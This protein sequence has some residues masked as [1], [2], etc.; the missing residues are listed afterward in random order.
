MDKLY[1][2]EAWLREE[3]LVKGRM[4]EDL[5]KELSVDNSTILYWLHKYNIPVRPYGAHLRGK[6]LSNDHREKLCKA[7]EGRKPMLGKHHSDA[8]KKKFSEI[9]KR[10]NL[11]EETRKKLSEASKGNKRGAG[12]I[13][14]DEHKRKIGQSLKGNKHL[15][16]H[17]HSEDTRK[18]ISHAISGEKNGMFGAH[19]VGP[20]NPAWKGGKSFE[21]YCTKFNKTVKEEVREKFGRKCYLCSRTEKDNG[22]KLDVHHADYDK[23]QGCGKKWDLLPLCHRCHSKTNN[24]RHY[25]FNLLANYWCMN[26]EINLYLPGG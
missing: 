12:H 11:S 23:G 7:R 14:T 18:R 1:Q 2:D 20:D 3:Y 9:H 17:A 21:P 26:L 22:K 24:N 15:L 19:R 6:S 13:H 5:A 4:A 10:E 25:Y 16:G 8:T